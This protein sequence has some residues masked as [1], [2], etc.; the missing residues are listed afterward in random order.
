MAEEPLWSFSLIKARPTF[1]LRSQ[2]QIL[3]M[4]LFAALLS[5]QGAPIML[6]GFVGQLNHLSSVTL[7]DLEGQCHK[8]QNKRDD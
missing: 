7:S 6:Q 8:K 4:A 5:C 3:K 2:L 1:W